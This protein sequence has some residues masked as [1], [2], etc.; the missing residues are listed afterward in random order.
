MQR[1]DR[2]T[3]NSNRVDEF[4]WFHSKWY[5]KEK[6]TR[7]NLVARVVVGLD[8]TRARA[9]NSRF[10]QDWTYSSRPSE[11][12]ELRFLSERIERVEVFVRANYS[13]SDFCSTNWIEQ[14]YLFVEHSIRISIHTKCSNWM[15][16]SKI[17]HRILFDELSW[18]SNPV[19]RI[20]LNDQ[21]CSSPSSGL[22][23]VSWS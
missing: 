20:D 21:P 8:W 9:F 1:I 13:S 16:N 12:N 15:I 3:K 7:F 10:G 23:R 19:R 18:T 4:I 6:S 14:T 17:D 5:K 11:S 2:A 22:A